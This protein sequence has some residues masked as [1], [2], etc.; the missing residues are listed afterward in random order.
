MFAAAG[1]TSA[2]RHTTSLPPP[3]GLFRQSLSLRRLLS[4]LALLEQKDG[5]LN[6]SSLAA[7]T[8][9]MKL[10]GSVTGF[11]AGDGI[12]SVAE[13]AAKVKGLEK[14]IFVDSAAYDKVCYLAS[15][16]LVFALCS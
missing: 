9:A 2:L 13:Q 14:V 3:N 10:G 11:L 12:K 7:V 8:A 4:S 1:R 15:C 5:K 16:F 6:V